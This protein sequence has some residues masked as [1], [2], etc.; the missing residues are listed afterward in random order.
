MSLTEEAVEWVD[1]AQVAYENDL[2]FRE[3]V[4]ELLHHEKLKH[5][6]AVIKYN[7][8]LDQAAKTSQFK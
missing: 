4:Q 3:K 5:E 1:S 2:Q 6:L 8:E 7:V